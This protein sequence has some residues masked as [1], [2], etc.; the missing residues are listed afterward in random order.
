[1]LRALDQT[2]LDLSALDIPGGFPD[3]LRSR[4]E[5]PICALSLSK[6]NRPALRQAQR[7]EL[8][9]QRTTGALQARGEARARAQDTGGAAGRAR[10]PHWTHR[11]QSRDPPASGSSASRNLAKQSGLEVTDDHAAPGIRRQSRHR[12]DNRS[13]AGRRDLPSARAAVEGS[14]GRSRPLGTGRR[15]SRP[16]GNQDGRGRGLRGRRSPLHR[17]GLQPRR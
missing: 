14:A 15:L 9:A 4:P 11:G 16:D 8:K 5:Q 1:M 17:R 13:S 6:G 3:R 12:Q 10:R 7:T 2:S